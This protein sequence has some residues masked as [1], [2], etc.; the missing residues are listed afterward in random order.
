MRAHKE[1]INN[2]PIKLSPTQS[3]NFQS[4][5]TKRINEAQLAR[6]S[7]NTQSV[8]IPANSNSFRI[9]RIGDTEERL[10]NGG[11]AKAKSKTQVNAVL[12]RTGSAD[13]LGNE[14]T[15]RLPNTCISVSCARKPMMDPKIADNEPKDNIVIHCF[16][17]MVLLVAP[18]HFKVAHTSA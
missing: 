8:E 4:R 1:K 16:F 2:A 5:A 10:N 14:A 18:K 15:N 13:G 17:K 12:Q 6:A 7:T 9:K 11:P 3:A